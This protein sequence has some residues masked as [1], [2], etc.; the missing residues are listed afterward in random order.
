MSDIMLVDDD[1]ELIQS[2]VRVLSPLLAPKTIFAAG[3]TAKA[4]ELRRQY[5][6]RVAVVDLCL[7]ERAGVESGFDLLVQLKGEDPD[8]RIIMLTGH[9][10][11]SYGIRA[12]QL[13]A[14]SFVEKPADPHH[15]A[16]LIKDAISHV[17]LV[18]AYR[19]LVK[20]STANVA[21]ELCGNSDAV[22]KLREEIEFAASTNQPV[23]LLGETGTGKSMCAR[24]IH[25]RSRRRD[26]KFVFYHPNFAGGDIVQSELFGHT[27]GAFTG[28]SES[29]RGLA[30]E[31]EGGTL[32]IDEL[33]SVPSDTQVLL[34]DLVQERR[35]RPVGSDEF[36]NV[37]CRFVAATNVPIEDAVT[38]HLIRK[39]LYHRLAHCVIAIPPLRERLEDV[40]QLAGNAL[41]RLCERES[42]RVSAFER[43]VE[44][45]LRSYSWPGNIRE[46]QGVVENAA[47][48][49]QFK[50]RL[51]IRV[52]DIQL[53]VSPQD[54]VVQ[55]VAAAPSFHEQVEVFKRELIRHALEASGGNQVQAATAL[56]I[57]RGTIR[58]ILAE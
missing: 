17:E 22:Q 26:R 28:A 19:A 37:D 40:I 1:G 12:M 18:N 24:L 29:R 21:S 8:M 47:Y 4:L 42:L 46:L 14:A 43:G 44:D 31:A 39:D 5:S 41:S 36:H 3:S 38:R 51:S 10:S 34:L 25:Q 15:V 32:F 55:R 52:E 9:G 13:G 45:V 53:H 50:G 6:P 48:R 54:R 35:V 23:L 49:A 33:D 56:G 16:A 2:L 11:T 58:R 30:Q 27:K 20:D 7:D 57:D